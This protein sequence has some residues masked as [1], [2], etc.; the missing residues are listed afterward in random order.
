MTAP[1]PWLP[2]AGDVALSWRD[3]A[4]WREDQ[5]E[6]FYLN[7]LTYGQQLWLK[8]LPA[9]ALLAVDRAL[10]SNVP[11]SAPCLKD[12][13]LPYATIAWML[14]QPTEHFTGNARVH[15]QHLADRVRGPR[16]GLIRWRAWAAWAVVCKANPKLDRDERHLVREPSVEDI[17]HGLAQHGHPSE[18]SQWQQML[19]KL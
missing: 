17:A 4:A 14:Q 10:F 13:P 9:R 8:N 15:Y 7:C 5:G 16:A 19:G 6:T 2:P 18:A 3:L 1:C 12:Y 11:A